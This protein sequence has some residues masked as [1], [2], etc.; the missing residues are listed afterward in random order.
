[1]TPLLVLLACQPDEQA[2]PNSSDSPPTNIGFTAYEVDTTASTAQLK[3][4][5][6]GDITV[7]ANVPIKGGRLATDSISL[8]AG[9]FR[10][11]FDRMVV[12]QQNLPDSL[13]EY[14]LS[15][16]TGTGGRE[17][18]AINILNVAPAPLKITYHDSARLDSATHILHTQLNR[19]DTLT[20]Q[21]LTAI[22]KKPG[23]TLELSSTFHF[24][25]AAMR[26]SRFNQRPR[27]ELSFKL[28]ANQQGIA[29]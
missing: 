1:M 7:I 29:H 2:Q 17:G 16:I 9:A 15:R 14:W 12:K 6:P 27:A 23:S 10:L 13:K 20:A 19:G 24:D 21:H 4:V 5:W 11:A 3:L 18:L 28:R 8:T 22:L 26:W 25:A